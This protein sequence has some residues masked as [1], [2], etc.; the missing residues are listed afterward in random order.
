[1]SNPVFHKT[2]I[3]NLGLQWHFLGVCVRL[4]GSL[5]VRYNLGGLKAP[6]TI[7]VDQRNLANG[8]PHSFNMSRVDRSVTIQVSKDFPGLET[9]V[10]IPSACLV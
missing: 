4:S 1:M 2:N 6:F 8:Q 5:Q 3:R 10:L 9:G 7:D